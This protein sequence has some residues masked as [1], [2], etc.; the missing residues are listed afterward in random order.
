MIENSQDLKNTDRE[1][2]RN[3]CMKVETRGQ[4]NK[5]FKLVI[6]KLDPFFNEQ[7]REKAQ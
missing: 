1:N 2:E 7:T 5:A 6:Y 4:F 3:A